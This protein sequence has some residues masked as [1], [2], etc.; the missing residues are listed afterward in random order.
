M[1]G[2]LNTLNRKR[3]R[4]K[5]QASKKKK[6]GRAFSIPNKISSK[7]LWFL[8]TFIVIGVVY[9]LYSGWVM[10][11]KVGFDAKTTWDM[12]SGQN[13]LVMGMDEKPNGYSFVDSIILLSVDL[14]GERL[15]VFSVD[16]EMKFV[17][18]GVDT[19]LQKSINIDFGSNEPYGNV[20]SGVEDILAIEVDKYVV[21]SEED[22][23]K[24]D[25]LV[26]EVPVTLERDISDPDFEYGDLSLSAGHYNL[27]NREVLGIIS[28]DENGIDERL[29]VQSMVLQNYFDNLDSFSRL[30]NIWLNVEDLNNVDTNL[31]RKEAWK[32]FRFVY[33]LEIDQIV[34]GYTKQ[35]SLVSTDSGKD[36][37]LERLDK[38][39]ES[40][41]LNP[42][43]LQEQA[44]VE[45]LNGTNEVGLAGKYSRRLSNVGIRVV[46]SGNAINT[47]GQTILYVKDPEKYE[48]T[49]N[50]ISSVFDDRLVV[51]Q[52]DYKYRHIGE[53]VLI[54]G[55]DNITY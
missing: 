9:F 30:V 22:F 19:T 54:V 20:V 27:G 46:R 38:D 10:Y 36:V 39:L 33:N 1:R 5:Y 3:R 23:L 15:G 48:N 55:E 25:K 47:S 21:L 51:L 44:R 13:I 28:A 12:E 49:I 31:S 14:Q 18:N 11:H 26:G 29:A 6:S 37:I 2:L 7:V 40:I 24:M 32:L 35:N 34:V 43:I 53:I 41:F 17:A 52:E 42:E 8:L 4:R 50:F 16:P 45:V